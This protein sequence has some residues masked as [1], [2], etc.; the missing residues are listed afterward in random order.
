MAMSQF[1]KM[2]RFLSLSTF[3]GNSFLKKKKKKKTFMGNS[4]HSLTWEK[5]KRNTVKNK[6]L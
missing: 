1:Y 4:K 5:K 3:M 6:K 2:L